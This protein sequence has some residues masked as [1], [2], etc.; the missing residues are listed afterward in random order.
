M[1]ALVAI[2]T[3]V[4]V[5]LAIAVTGL[6]RSHGEILRR[7]HALGVGLDPD[8]DGNDTPV[9]FGRAEIARPATRSRRPPISRARAC[10]T[11]P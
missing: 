9:A 6:L 3:V 5:L 8:A 2:E 4:L 11:T 1:T 7:L 10:T